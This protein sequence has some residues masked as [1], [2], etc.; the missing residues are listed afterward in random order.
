MSIYILSFQNLSFQ[1]ID[2]DA[3]NSAIF[4]IREN[5]WN[6][7][8][9]FQMLISAAEK[10]CKSSESES[11]VETESVMSPLVPEVDVNGKIISCVTESNYFAPVRVKLHFLFSSYK[12]CL[13]YIIFLQYYLLIILKFIFCLFV[14]TLSSAEHSNPSPWSLYGFC[15]TE[16][17]NWDLVIQ[18][19]FIQLK[20]R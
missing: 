4:Y 2:F 8:M 5:E 12:Y 15:Q 17:F 18:L 14:W 6:L 16:I 1:V 20:F 9:H 19:G 13:L 11:E 10:D 7:M 3:Y